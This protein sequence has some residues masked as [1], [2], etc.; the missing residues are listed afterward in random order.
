MEGVLCYVVLLLC[1]SYTSTDGKMNSG[2]V[3]DSLGHM[4]APT[5]Q[6]MR[7]VHRFPFRT[8]ALTPQG[9]GVL[10]SKLWLVMAKYL[11]PYCPRL[12]TISSPRS[13][14]LS[15]GQH[16]S[17]DWQWGVDIKKS[18]LWF[19][20]TALYRAR[21]ASELPMALA[22][23]FAVTISLFKYLLL[24][25]IPIPLLPSEFPIFKSKHGWCFL[26]SHYFQC[27]P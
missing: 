3:M 10:S 18:G 1:I 12:K 27:D 22:E 5:H 26:L 25:L 8:K 4:T 16:A 19:N 15:Q 23:A 11:P 2:I 17:K 20:L 21:P 9:R 24:W 13:T 14:V 7:C 6:K